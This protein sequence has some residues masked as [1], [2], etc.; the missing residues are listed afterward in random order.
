[1]QSVP[2]MTTTF[3][4]SLS[5]FVVITPI[6]LAVGGLQAPESVSDWLLLCGTGIIGYIGQLL[7]C[8]SLQLEAAGPA[9]MMR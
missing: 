5:G 6:A 7:M 3:W 4:F 8:R 2:P 9:T 1:M